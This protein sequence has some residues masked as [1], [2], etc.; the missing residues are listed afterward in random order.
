MSAGDLKLSISQPLLE[1]IGATPEGEGVD[2]FALFGLSRGTPA[3]GAV[4]A[5]VL[6]RSK[7]LRRWQSSPQYGQEVVALLKTLHRAAKILQDEKRRTAYLEAL[8]RAEKGAQ[9]SAA[10]EFRDL[11]R[12]ALVDGEISA[13]ARKALGEYV[14][15]RKL[16]GYT[17]QKITKEVREELKAQRAAA[18]KQ[19]A[20]E[21]NWEFRINETG[22]EGY[23]LMLMG[24]AQS[25]RLRDM[26][27]GQLMAEAQKYGVAPERAA[28]LITQ[29]K[30]REFETLVR[31]AAGN[32]ALST[33]QAKLIA[34]K[35][36]SYGL[37]Q[38]QAAQILSEYTF[39][40]ADP[41]LI[42]G[43]LELAETFD[44]DEISQIIEQ[45]AAPRMRRSRWAG[46]SLA[47]PPWLQGLIKLVLVLAI[48][49][50]GGWWLKN[51]F[52]AFSTSGVIENR[53]EPK[54]ESPESTQPGGGTASA[55]N[56]AMATATPAATNPSGTAAPEEP[57]PNE[58]ALISVPDPP[59]GFLAL[60]PE[61]PSDPPV[62]D[63][64][65]TEV[66]NDQ[67]RVF[68]KNTLNEAPA[69]WTNGQPP[70]GG[71]QKPVTDVTWQ[72]ASRYCRW[73][74]ALPEQARYD[75]GLPTQA[76]YARALHGRTLRGIM[77]SDPNYWS[78]ARLGTGVGPLVAKQTRWDKI[79]V[80]GLGQV[81]DLVGNVA[82]WG[83]E[84]EGG[85]YAVLGGDFSQTAPDFNHTK[86]RW[87]QDS[88]HLPTLG[89]RI[90]RHPK[91]PNS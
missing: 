61:H 86:T 12:A 13:E 87:M 58:G 2:Y 20:Q 40:A 72:L 51:S 23:G 1:A 37:D 62:F 17:A 54:R 19:Q 14:E 68:L 35:A 16:D 63:I 64:A 15:I 57:E 22:E 9:L 79:F 73:F 76:E 48:V 67:Y 28:L 53:A 77:P 89:F 56:G 83:S 47:P 30:V 60:A 90:V 3:P 46:L 85:K 8:Q 82:E 78:R 7:Q 81:Y 43:N 34:I 52:F 25:G 41:E 70:A 24:Q 45:G 21:D 80:A 55:S 11:V 4:E 75:I 91:K 74:G 36:S 29:Y 65:I 38:Q 27:A 49:I 5:A 44:Q 88:T 26:T 50:G 31:V 33:A 71:E 18:A 66:T 84:T 59:S 42:L 32:R 10:D 6:D 69:N 39:S